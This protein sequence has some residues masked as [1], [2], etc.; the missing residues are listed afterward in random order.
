MDAEQI[1]SLQKRLRANRTRVRTDEA[2]RAALVLPFIQSLG[3]DIFDPEE[4][5]PG[6]TRG[7]GRADFV[8]LDARAFEAAPVAAV[9]LG[10]RI[11]PGFHGNWFPKSWA[12]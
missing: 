7:Q 12:E 2:A 1:S 10:H 4:V 11:P 8:I 5:V 3:Y 6:F 9:H